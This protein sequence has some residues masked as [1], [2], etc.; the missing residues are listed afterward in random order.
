MVADGILHFHE[1]VCV[2]SPSPA[3]SVIGCP[4]RADCSSPEAGIF[5]LLLFLIS[6]LE[7]TQ[8]RHRGHCTVPAWTESAGMDV[9]PYSSAGR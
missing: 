8:K 3:S 4:A 2:P 5:C 6:R 9:A 1:V 7:R